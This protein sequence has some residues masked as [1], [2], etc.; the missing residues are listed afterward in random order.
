MTAV[1]VQSDSYMSQCYIKQ[2][3][4]TSVCLTFFKLKNEG[5]MRTLGI[6]FLRDNYVVFDSQNRELYIGRAKEMPLIYTYSYFWYYT[7]IVLVFF[8]SIV[9]ITCGVY[10]KEQMNGIMNLVCNIYKFLFFR[11]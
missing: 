5:E 10:Y 4:Q 11:D 3:N 6:P 7:M 8:W 1:K 9:M 2:E